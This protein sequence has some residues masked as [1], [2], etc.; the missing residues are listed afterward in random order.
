MSDTEKNLTEKDWILLARKSLSEKCDFEEA[1]QYYFKAGEINPDNAETKFFVAHYGY[2]MLLKKSD[3]AGVFNAFKAMV[4]HGAAAIEAINAGFREGNL[5]YNHD[6]VAAA[7]AM[8]FTPIP[9]YVITR[10]RMT[11]AIEE[12]VIGLYT[13][14]DALVQYYGNSNEITKMAVEAW[15]E[16]VALQRQFY[17]YKYRGITPESYAAK[18]QQVEPTYVMPDKAGCISLPSK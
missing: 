11:G 2:T 12:G 5:I 8:T 15:K 17:A 14:G 18:I 16:G 10:L 4:Q 9:R 7:I 13:L 6:L 3:R 1:G